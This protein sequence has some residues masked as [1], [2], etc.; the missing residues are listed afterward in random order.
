MGAPGTFE[1]TK[2]AITGRRVN[3]LLLPAAFSAILAAPPTSHGAS[4]EG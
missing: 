4:R 3:K 1:I 2:L